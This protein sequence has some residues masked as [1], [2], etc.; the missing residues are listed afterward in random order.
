MSSIIH[1]KPVVCDGLP[2][3]RCRDETPKGRKKEKQM[4]LFKVSIHEL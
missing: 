3:E 4:Q 2:A 1:F